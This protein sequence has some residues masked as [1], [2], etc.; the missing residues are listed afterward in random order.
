M[1]KSVYALA[2]LTTLAV[3]AWPLASLAACTTMASE[4]TTGI[5]GTTLN[6]A[7]SGTA[8]TSLTPGST[9]NVYNS[10]GIPYSPG[11]SPNAGAA[12]G[13]VPPGALSPTSPGGIN[14]VTNPTIPQHPT[15]PPGT[16]PANT[17]PGAG[18]PA[19]G[20]GGF[21]R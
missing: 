8:P 2:V 14:S 12:A 17:I 20:S 15:T 4:S 7:T 21:G 18:A 10:P 11:Y 5:S 13:S 6:G 16:L 9:G 3:S 1:T 19:V